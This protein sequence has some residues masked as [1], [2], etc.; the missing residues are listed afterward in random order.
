MYNWDTKIRFVR[1]LGPQKAKEL[2][3]IGINTV[4]DLLERQPLHY[5][6]PGGVSIANAKEGQMVVI[7]AKIKAIGWRRSGCID[8]ALSDETGTCRAV[9]YNNWGP[10][11]YLRL[12]TTATFWG[13]Y[14][15]KILQQPKWSTIDAALEDVYGG[16]YGIHHQT[17]RAA[18]KEVW[19]HVELPEL[20]NGHECSRINLFYDYHFPENKIKQQQALYSLKLDELLCQQLA[21]AER[22]RGREQVGTWIRLDNVG[23]YFPYEFTDDQETAIDEIGQDLGKHKVMQRLIHGEVGSGKTAIA[24]YTAIGCAIQG[25]RTLILCPTTILAQQ[26]YDTLKGMG[27]DDVGLKTGNFVDDRQYMGGGQIIIGTHA[28]FNDEA[29]L[30]SASLV[31]IDEFQKFGVSQRAKIQ[32]HNPHLLLL[33]A[34]PIPRTLAASVFRDL[35]V[36]VIRQLPIERG[37]VVTRWVLPSCREAM[38]EVVEKELVKGKQAYVVYPRISGDEDMVSAE[39]GFR[40]LSKRFGL[41]NTMLLTGR[42]DVENKAWVLRQFRKGYTKILVS[43]IIAEVGLDCPNANIMVVEGADRFGL[44]Q[45]HQLRGR[46][47]RS[48]DTAFCFLVSD[49]ANEK[50]I[51]RLEVIERCNDGFEIAEHDLRL[52]GPGELFSTRQHGLPALKFASL[53]DD[54]DLMVEAK[55]L[56]QTIPA[57]AG[58]RDMMKLKYGDSLQLGEV[59]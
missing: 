46:V 18:L 16:Q 58:V 54:Y 43:T 27:W 37:T 57:D 40:E 25:K 17:I 21:L 8:A 29:L 24:F 36:S 12:G 53:V 56:A 13:K 35:D 28:I 52:R 49:S 45:L 48:T 10:I 20:Y 31:I 33:S 32:K 15:D 6:Y 23:Y 3:G 1:G 42:S 47:C 9:W 50:S 55:E 44:S 59:T 41:H 11:K 4:G 5:L 39:K 51:A 2:A 19:T 22:R 26:H 7:K 14:K 30:K 38:Y 34:T